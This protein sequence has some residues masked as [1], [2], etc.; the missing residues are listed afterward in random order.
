M[1]KKMKKIL[2][3]KKT[4]GLAVVFFFGLCFLNVAAQAAVPKLMTYQGVLKDSSGNYLTGTYSMVFRIY[5]ASS[6]GS[7]LWSETQSSVSASSGKF[8]VQLGSVTALNLDFNADYWLSVQVGS[9]AEMSPRIRLTST[10]YVIRAEYENNGFSQASHNAMSHKDIEGVKDNTVNLAKTNFK[11]DA[12]SVAAANSLGDMII[13]TFNDASGINSSA[14][15]GY[16]WRGASNY[17]VILASGGGSVIQSATSDDDMIEIISNVSNSYNGFGQG[18]RHGSAVTIDKVAFKCTKVGSP[19][20]N[21]KIRI[22]S[23][24][25]SLPGTQLAESSAIDVSTLSANPT[26]AE[27]EATLTSPLS[28]SAN[29]DYFAVIENISVSGS[30]STH[31]NVKRSNNGNPYANGGAVMKS[32]TGTWAS[33]GSSADAYFKIYEQASSSGSATVISNAFNEPVAPTEAMVVADET[34]GTGSITYYVSRDNGTTWTQCTKDTVTSISSQPSG[35]QLKWKAVIT[36]NSELNA[37][38]IAV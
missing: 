33:A 8:S 6:G 27:L 20:G 32:D 25:S 9:D 4:F 15:S 5:S 38:A 37:I 21:I 23:S 14:S 2:D 29:T 11:L 34:L 30:G 35:T 3:L 7:S 28:I 26:Y 22:Y 36:G 24:S 16:T 18:F 10:G 13:D 17:D 1:E 31:V 12:Y 19:T